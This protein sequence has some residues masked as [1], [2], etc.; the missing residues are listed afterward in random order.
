MTSARKTDRKPAPA[1]ATGFPRTLKELDK[2]LDK[3][4][5]PYRCFLCTALIDL[6]R[7]YATS[8]ASSNRFRVLICSECAEH[9]K[10]SSDVYEIHGRRMRATDERLAAGERVSLDGL[11]L[12]QLYGGQH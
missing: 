7:G 8:L 9:T 6:K 1:P 11:L 3:A 5:A 12:P 4:K 10:R 2:F